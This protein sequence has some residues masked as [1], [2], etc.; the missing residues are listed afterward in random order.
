MIRNQIQKLFPKIAANYRYMRDSRLQQSKSSIR[1]NEG[2]EFI[3]DADIGNSREDSHELTAFKELLC[4]VDCLLDVGANAGFFSMVA[5][6]L[7]KPVIAIEPNHLNYELLL[8]NIRANQFDAVEPI[9]A[10]VGSNMEVAELF[11]GGQG[12][13]LLRNWGGMSATYSNLVY[14]TTLDSLLER[15][16]PD[17]RILV[18]LDVEGA[19]HLV[20]RGAQKILSRTPATDWIV[21][22]GFHENFNGEINPNFRRVFDSFWE[23]DYIARTIDE[24]P[25]IVTPVDVDEWLEKRQRG[26]GWMYYTFCKK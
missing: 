8:R 14:C 25:R 12:A 9:F 22:H 19:E 15:C 2:F 4:G 18:K 11:G 1:Y 7:G 3:G 24:K 17:H 16:L 20:L 10:A 26:F 6:N 21:E 23:H 5:A 13:S